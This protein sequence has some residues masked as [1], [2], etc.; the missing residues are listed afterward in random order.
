MS[1]APSL[2]SGLAILTA[3]AIWLAPWT[4]S[5]TTGADVI[6][7]KAVTGVA[8]H[9]FEFRDKADAALTEWALGRFQQAGLEL[10]PL[11]VAFHDDEEPCGG[12]PGLYRDGTP[13]RIDMCGFN[14][15]RFIPKAKVTLL[16]ELGHA[17]AAHTLT[18]EARQQF[19]DFRGLPTWGDDQWPWEEQGSEQAAE[20][21]AWA[22]LD[23]DYGM[24]SISDSDPRAL[25]HAYLQLTS[26]PPTLRVVGILSRPGYLK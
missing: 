1:I 3:V 11:I 6:N 24:S 9:T 22:L 2:S 16:H 13:A 8:A 5:D 26:T 15:D 25:A 19:V 23:Q 18:P 14:W 10:P 20:T 7:A 21:I 4:H 17:W 12:H